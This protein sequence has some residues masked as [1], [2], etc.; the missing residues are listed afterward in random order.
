M[1]FNCTSGEVLRAGPV[2]P[3]E[4]I[5]TLSTIALAAMATLL[6]LI[7]TVMMRRPARQRTVRR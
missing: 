7:G 1:V 2:N 5:P 4:P 3:A 6:A